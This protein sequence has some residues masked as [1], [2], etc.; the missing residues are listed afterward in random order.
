M[1]TFVDVRRDV[2]ALGVKLERGIPM[3]SG[4]GRANRT[5]T[6]EQLRIRR[7]QEFRSNACCGA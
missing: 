3:T 7:N 2:V 4:E 1:D 6:A 5:H